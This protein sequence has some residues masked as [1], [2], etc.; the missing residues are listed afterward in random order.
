MTLNG[1]MALILRYF[2][3][4]D[5]LGGRLRHSVVEDRPIMSAEYLRLVLANFDPRRSSFTIYVR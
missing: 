1:V 2:T 5:C 3:E 4:F